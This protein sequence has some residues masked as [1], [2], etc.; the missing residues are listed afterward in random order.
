MSLSND[1]LRCITDGIHTIK[2]RVTLRLAIYRQSVRL[3]AKPLQMHGHQ[4][5]LF[6]T[7]P[8]R[9]QSFRIAAG[10]RPHSHSQ[11]RAYETHDHILLPQIRDLPNLDGQFPVFISPRNRVA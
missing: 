9:P 6:S 5:I 7:E 1:G 3:G 2:K 4:F 11:V 8:L 10:P